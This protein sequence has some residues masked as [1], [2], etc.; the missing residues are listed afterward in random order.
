M[1]SYQNFLK[2]VNF[3][4]PLSDNDIKAIQSVCREKRCLA[5]EIII[6]EG[7]IGKNFYIIIEGSVEIWKRYGTPEQDIIASYGQ[8]QLFGEMALIDKQP[9]SATAVACKPS[10]LLFITRDDFNR[11][12]KASNPISFSIMR[13]ISDKIRKS[14]KRYIEDL[15]ARN[16]L[17]ILTCEQLQLEV[18]ERKKTEELLFQAKNKLEQR[19]M[20]RMADL[21]E[22]NA[23]LSQEIEDRKLLQRQLLRSERL[24]STGQ[25]AA[26]VA[27]EINSPLQ[28]ITALLSTLIAEYQTDSKL[29]GRFKIFKSAVSNIRNAVQQLLDLNRPSKETKQL[30]DINTIIEN[31]VSLVKSQLKNARIKLIRDLDPNLPAIIASPQQLAQCLLNLINNANESICGVSDTNKSRRAKIRSD[32]FAAAGKITIRTLLNQGHIIITVAD[33]GP[34]IATEAISYLFDPFYTNKKC[35]GVGIGLS[36]S[37]GI[38]EEHH[39]TIEAEN[40]LQGGAV[41]TIKLPVSNNLAVSK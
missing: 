21:A 17:L 38:I 34:G 33:N 13:S 24:A 11:V 39:G 40:L 31:T 9:R 8:G 30:V 18:E 12:I 4:R 5:G 19:V 41:F 25:L 6:S 3:F 7:S 35:M 15:K 29:L 23:R 2:K 37:F 28:A 26:S 32:A 10:R 27:H 36:V 1:S 22:T 20:A 16:R 14:N